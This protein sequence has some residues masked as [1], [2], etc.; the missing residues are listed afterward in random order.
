MFTSEARREI[1]LAPIRTRRSHDGILTYS[2]KHPHTRTPI[3][4]SASP[5]L[6]ASLYYSFVRHPPC[7]EPSTTLITSCEPPNASH[8]ASPPTSACRARRSHY[9]RHV[10]PTQPNRT[11]LQQPH[12]TNTCR[13]TSRSTSRRPR[14]R[15]AMCLQNP[16]R[17][18]EA[19]LHTP[20]DT[21][22]SRIW[23]PVACS[24]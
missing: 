9:R 1:G 7:N 12:K 5:R 14:A 20:Q 10:P 16:Y 2:C 23:R 22:N 19:R 3:A 15:R 24:R 4:F 11:P 13:R 18:A 17:V 21:T 8:R 6:R